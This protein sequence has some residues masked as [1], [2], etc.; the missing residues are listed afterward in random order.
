MSLATSYLFLGVAVFLGVSEGFTKLTPSILCIL[1]MCVTMFSMAKAM[2]ALPVG[3]AYSTYSGLVVTGVV[4]FAVLKYNQ[5][6]NIYGIT[7]IILIIIGVIMV[8]YLGNI[9]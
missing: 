9:K 2:T 8:N 6:P 1:F 7:G 5:I 3:F 4:L